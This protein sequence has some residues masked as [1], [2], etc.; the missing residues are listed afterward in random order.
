MFKL[1][2]IEEW[3]K[4]FGLPIGE[5]PQIPSDKEVEFCLSLIEEE[6]AELKEALAAKNLE[7]V[8]D[9]T[10]DLVWVVVRLKLH[11]GLDPDKIM[12][13]VSESNFSKADYYEQDA[14]GTFEKYRMVGVE[15]VQKQVGNAILTYRKSD[16]K[17]LKSINF[18]EPNFKECL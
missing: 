3:S 6:L 12:K 4:I 2:K 15:V 8:C 16:G 18:Q 5:K 14:F 13:A 17:L 11:F 1:E 9:A 7:G 10:G